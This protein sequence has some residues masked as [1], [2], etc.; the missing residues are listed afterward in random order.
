MCK[1]VEMKNK[2]YS[3]WTVICMTERPKGIKTQG[4]HWL[5][6]CECG[7]KEIISG[8]KLRAGRMKR[9]CLVCSGR[10]HKKGAREPRPHMSHGEPCGNDA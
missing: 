4:A 5:C 8:A 10:L 1:L 9:G 6:Q 2:K 3:P 7:N